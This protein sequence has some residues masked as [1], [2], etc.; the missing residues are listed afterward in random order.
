MIQIFCSNKLSSLFGVK[1][2]DTNVSKL[3]NGWS[4]HLF[5]VGGRKCIIFVDKLTLYSIVIIDILK[6]DTVQIRKI[7]QNEL[8]TQLHAD[9]LLNIGDENSIIKLTETIVI[10][11]TDNDRKTMGSLNDF[12]YH[13]KASYEDTQSLDRVRTFVRK[14]LNEMPSKMLRFKTPKEVMKDQIKNYA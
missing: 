9:N 11:P 12:V 13:V 5:P 8:I 1:N 6:K 4:A 3:E 14:Y 2:L 10:C 7:F